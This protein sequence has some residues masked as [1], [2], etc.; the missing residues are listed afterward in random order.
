MVDVVMGVGFFEVAL[1]AGVAVLVCV[2]VVL[3]AVCEIGVG[4]EADLE[5]PVIE[6]GGDEALDV[7]G[8][9]GCFRCAGELFAL[10]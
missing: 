2:D 10:D 1:L 7:V 9:A 4:V 3:G 5:G 8:R 6:G